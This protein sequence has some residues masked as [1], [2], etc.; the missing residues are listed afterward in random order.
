MSLYESIL[1][2]LCARF[3]IN[4]PQESFQSWERLLFEVRTTSDQLKPIYSQ[5]ASGRACMVVLHGFS[6]PAAPEAGE[7]SGNQRPSVLDQ[8]S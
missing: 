5:N 1:S 4:S 6:H 3:V 7:V 8:C 2:D